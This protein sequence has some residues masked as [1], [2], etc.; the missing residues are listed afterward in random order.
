[1]DT[2]KIKEIQEALE[3]GGNVIKTRDD[4]ELILIDKDGKV[5]NEEDCNWLPDGGK[6]VDIA[7]LRS[8]I[9]PW[10]TS[11]FQSEHLSLLC[12]SGITNAISCLAEAGGGT[13]M[14]AASFTQFKDEIEKA[15]EAT[16]KASGRDKGN[17]ED[18]IRTANDLLR[19]LKILKKDT[20]AAALETDLNKIISE[21]AKSI[22]TTENAIATAKDDKREN[23]L[24]VL[25]NFLLSFASRT[26]NRERLNV[27]TTNY[28]RLI[29]VG[30]EL[31][32]VH[33]MDRF[34]GTMMPIFRSS[35]LNLDIHY[36]PPGIRGEPRYLEGVARLTK[37]HGSVDWIQNENEIRRLGLPFGASDIAPYLNAPGLKGADTLRVMIYPNSAKDRETAEYPY[38][39]LFR[40]FA[41]A[42]CRPNSTLVTYGYGFGD[43]HINRIIHDM[44]TIPSTHLVVISYNDPI[45]RILQFYNDSAHYAQMSV[46]MGSNLGDIS[47]L[48]NDYLPKSAID[49]ATIR[50]AELLQHRLGAS[51]SPTTPSSSSGTTT[52]G[53]TVPPVIPPAPSSTPST[54]TV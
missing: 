53:T 31:A 54:L 44:L 7:I 15:A 49:R 32:G 4:R 20:E 46:L 33:L 40:D 24:S 35:R 29:E 13:T 51:S 17:I 12:G 18:Q 10:L 22:L 8:R 48:A 52:T 23:A 5:Q 14:G 36:N 3:A 30:A 25:V 34:V 1:M 2:K 19:G 9:E 45:G 50:M 38:V 37:L 16:A 11:L 6:E 47:T 42:I 41:A 28:D 27:F 43:E 21:F 39:E 26:G